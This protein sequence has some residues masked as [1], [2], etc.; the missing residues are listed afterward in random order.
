MATMRFS[1]GLAMAPDSS[2]A[3][4]ANAFCILAPCGKKCVIHIIRLKSTASRYQETRHNI[5]EPLH[6]SSFE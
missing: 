2:A 4:S 3:M 6:H 1:S 5:L